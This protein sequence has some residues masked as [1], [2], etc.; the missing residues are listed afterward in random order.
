MIRPPLHAIIWDFDNTLVD[1]RDRNRSVTR[2]IIRDVTGR[3]PDDFAPLRS[4]RAYDLAIHRNQNWQDLYRLEFRMTPDLIQAAG[5]LW[6]AYQ[7]E[8]STPT[9]WFEGIVEVVREFEDR[10]QAIVSM[11]TRDNIE[12][13][14]RVVGL[15]CAFQLVIGCGEVGYR[16][17]KPQPDGLLHCL[18]TLTEL[19]GGTVMYIGDHP[20]DAECAA[21]ANAE[22]ERR[23][24]ELRVTAVAA[25]YGS[26]GPDEGWPIEPDFRAR[27]PHEVLEIARAR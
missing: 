17:Q 20:V 9:A 25:T 1:T 13:A 7:F 26:A 5:R 8:D 14:L 23:Q 22:L 16:R 2:R 6:T 18:E 27:T 11:N 24:V 4:Q 19:E 15:E 3:D 21:N 10:P 12:A